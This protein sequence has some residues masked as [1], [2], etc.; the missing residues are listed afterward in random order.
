M[1]KHILTWS[2]WLGLACTVI[3]FVLRFLAALG[4]LYPQVA[5]GNRI[6]YGSFLHVAALFFLIALA[7]AS[8]IWA[9]SQK[10]Q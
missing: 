3:A 4:I 5:K 8:Y 2:Y 9:H 10:S 7:T 6:D 1:E